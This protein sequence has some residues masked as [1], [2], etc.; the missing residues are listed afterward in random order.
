MTEVDDSYRSEVNSQDMRAVAINETTRAGG[1][2]RS[3][4]VPVNKWGEWLRDCGL[5]PEQ[6]AERLNKILV[7]A[8]ARTADNPVST[9]SVY[10]MRN[11]H[12]L[13]G[14]DLALAIETLTDGAVP[15]GSWQRV[16]VRA[17][18]RKRRA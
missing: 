3:E 14:R 4:R 9:S 7:K 13:P 11:A 18:R 6:V 15:V 8:G 17:K 2:P 5:K 1:R 12:F 10:N 16:E